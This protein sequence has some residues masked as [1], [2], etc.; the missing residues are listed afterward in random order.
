M[1]VG[2]NERPSEM[3]LFVGKT[4]LK[5]IRKH[6][7]NIEELVAKKY[8]RFQIFVLG[9]IDK[10]ESTAICKSTRIGCHSLTSIGDIKSLMQVIGVPRGDIHFLSCLRYTSRS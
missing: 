2:R 5:R 6:I 7:Q 1:E 8:I 9:K 4:S 3:F 10:E